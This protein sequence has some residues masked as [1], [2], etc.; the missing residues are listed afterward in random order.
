MKV[1]LREVQAV[2]HQG[3]GMDPPTNPAARFAYPGQQS[4]P[5]PALVG[6]HLLPL[7]SARHD[8]T[9]RVR[10]FYTFRSCHGRILNSPANRVNL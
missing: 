1:F 7:T 10:I 9:T 8:V 5:V 6:A 2:A 3:P 4:R